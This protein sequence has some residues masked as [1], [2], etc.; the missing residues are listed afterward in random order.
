VHGGASP[1]P[2]PEVHSAEVSSSRPLDNLYWF[3]TEGFIFTSSRIDAPVTE[4]HAAV[5]VLAITD[6]PFT[7]TVAGRVVPERA[8]TYAPLERRELHAKGVALMSVDI[9]PHHAAFSLLSEAVPDG[10]QAL[11]REAFSRFDGE[12][13]RAFEGRLSHT[14]ARLLFEDLIDTQLAQ[15][16]LK[17]GEGARSQSHEILHGLLRAKP[18]VSLD[19]IAHV[20]GVSAES[21]SDAF[22][23]AIGLSFDDHQHWLRVIRAVESL[24]R[25]SRGKESPSEM[26]QAAG[27]ASEADL[28]RTWRQRFALSPSF[29]WDH[30]R[31]RVIDPPDT[32]GEGPRGAAWVRGAH[33]ADAGVASAVDLARGDCAD[34][35]ARDAKDRGSESR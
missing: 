9:Q 21:A 5:L 24:R 15:M 26:A 20:L 13:T 35:G 14:E 30:T 10:G 4:R 8:V 7:C 28:L 16:G 27:F 32:R 3:G 2:E 25:M 19:D 6:Q 12:L 31:V 33:E 34:A 11:R 29:S 23:E 22:A 17:R 1:C 18:D